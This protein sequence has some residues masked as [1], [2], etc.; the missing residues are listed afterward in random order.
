MGNRENA[1]KKERSRLKLPKLTA[2]QSTIIGAIIT[3]VLSLLV[4]IISLFGT[5]YVTSQARATSAELEKFKLNL[6]DRSNR[7]IETIRALGKATESIQKMKDSIQLVNDDPTM[8]LLQAREMLGK[9][10]NE[11]ELAFAEFGKDVRG[12]SSSKKSLYELF[13]EAKNLGLTASNYVKGNGQSESSNLT[14][15]ARETLKAIRSDLSDV[16]LEILT[17]YTSLTDTSDE[18]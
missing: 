9:S 18:E 2:A 17:K 8:T 5:I 16:Q 1:I 4:A 14:A 12:S 15:E 7:Q 10:A 11:L 3:S 13:H 6:Q